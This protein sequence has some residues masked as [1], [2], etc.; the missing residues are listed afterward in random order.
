[1]SFD[2]NEI[3]LAEDNTLLVRPNPNTTSVNYTEADGGEMIRQQNSTYDQPVNGLIV[4]KTTDYWELTS[5]LSLFFR[6]N[7]TYKIIYV[8]KNQTMFAVNG[9]W[10]STGLQIIP[11]PYEEYSTWS[12]TLTI[13]DTAWTEYAENSSG[14]QIYSHTVSVPLVGINAGGEIWDAVGLVSDNVDLLA[15][16]VFHCLCRD[17]CAVNVGSAYR[18]SVIDGYTENAVELDLVALVNVKFFDENDVAFAYLV[19]LS[20]C[21]DDRKH[22]KP[23]TFVL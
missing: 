4:P 7:H 16:S 1:M 9:A 5:K 14:E 3:Y 15:L 21:F 23:L 11:V 22:E 13:G 6:I 10:I 17:D 18:K 19:L 2:A 20:A 12:I 8:K